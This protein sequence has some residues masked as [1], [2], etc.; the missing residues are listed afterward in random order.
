MSW[1]LWGRSLFEQSQT[2]NK[3]N[4][5]LYQ[6]VKTINWFCTIKS[7][8]HN[9]VVLSI[10]IVTKYLLQGYFCWNQALAD[11]LYRI[12]AW[13]NCSQSWSRPTWRETEQ[14]R[15][16]MPAGSGAGWSPQT[17]IIIAAKYFCNK[18]QII[19]QITV[20]L[21]QLRVKLSNLEI[22][23]NNKG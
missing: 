11:T 2:Q 13:R 9:A 22:V 19:F 6:K 17:Q 20:Q 18:F 4:C 10:L 16:Q 3:L 8:C 14:N 15:K 1:C 5:D 23:V 7:N 12:M 21:Y